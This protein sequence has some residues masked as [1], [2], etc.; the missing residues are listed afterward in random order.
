[1]PYT[2]TLK[3]G[4]TL[5]TIADTTVDNTTSLTLIGRNFAGYGGY[6]AEDFVHQLENFAYT[7]APSAPLVGQ[8]WYNKNA[9]ATL[10]VWNGNCVD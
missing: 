1:M 9:P 8:L 4:T 10:M 3:D 5:T 2:I 7:A 6:I